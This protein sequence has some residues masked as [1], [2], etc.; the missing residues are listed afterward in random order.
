[1]AA[2]ARTAKA[3][4]FGSVFEIIDSQL[5]I[6]KKVEPKITKGAPSGGS[7]IREE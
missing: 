5:D 6:R 4:L 1:M 7:S 3:L 2:A